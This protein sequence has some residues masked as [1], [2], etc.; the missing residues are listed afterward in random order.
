MEQAIEKIKIAVIDDHGL[1]RKGLIKLI[2]TLSSSFD[3]CMEASNGQDFLNRLQKDNLPGLAILDIDMP[4]MDGY[5]IAEILKN[6]YPQIQVL[7]ITMLEDESS[8]IRMIKSGVKGYLSKDVEP[9]ELKQALET[10]S[11]G[12][13]HYNDSL[14]G[15]LIQVIL[16]DTLKNNGHQLNERE[17]A[18]LELCCTELTYKEIADRMFLSPKTIDGYRA[19]LFERFNAKSR[20]GLVLL[21][22]KNGWVKI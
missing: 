12:Q 21:A 1:Y 20:V 19:A 2:T 16:T 9:D 15:K 8:L 11:K 22:I 13:F 18:F 7:V 10:I 6:K 14:S 3:V 5:E 4:I 17:L